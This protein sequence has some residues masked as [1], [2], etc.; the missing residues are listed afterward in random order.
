[1]NRSEQLSFLI[2]ALSP[3]SAIP[4]SDSDKWML[5]RSLVNTR[6][7]GE[8]DSEFLRVESQFL[9]A[10][11]AAKGIT[12][13]A[14]L[15]PVRGGCCLWQGDITSL[16]ADAIVNAA[17]SGLTGC[18][19]P[20]HR[21]IDNAI[22]TFAGI[23]LRNEC[24]AIMQT[25]GHPE[26][27]GRAQI[28]SAYNLPSRFVIHTVGPV[29]QGGDH[30]EAEL[31]ASSYRSCLLLAQ[32][33]GLSSIAFCCISTGEFG[34]PNEEAARIA[35]QTV[36]DWKK[37]SGSSMTVVFNVFKDLDYDIYRQLLCAD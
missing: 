25:Q 14:D 21:C 33:R 17:N 4:E 24:A 15:R 29:W 16:A 30:C 34:F 3:V 6:D 7:P 37:E 9:K 10:E 22:H 26:P 18:W 20:C 19:V 28:T 27:V 13:A 5:F 12:R 35:V 1:M 8:A 11:I 36:L 23:E 32:E 31:L 2:R